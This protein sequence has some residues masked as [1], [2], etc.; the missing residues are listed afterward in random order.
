MCTCVSRARWLLY[1]AVC[2]MTVASPQL[3]T[4][5]GDATLLKKVC[6]CTLQ[7]LSLRGH[8]HLQSHTS[9]LPQVASRPSRCSDL[10]LQNGGTC[11]EELG[12][13][14][15][16]KSRKGQYCQEEVPEEELSALCTRLG[17]PGNDAVLKCTALMA[18]LSAS[19]SA[20]ASL[21]ASAN[22]SASP[23]AIPSASPGASLSASP[24]VS[25]SISLSA[26][27]RPGSPSASPSAIVTSFSMNVITFT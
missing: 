27:Q 9:T 5:H 11:N 12:R 4:A 26:R 21:S 22:A 3:P 14:D 2:T 24:S 8:Q 13:C 25:A 17:F 1:A 20:S 7:T 15:C 19:P 10:C 18:S 16:Q 23:S 6:A